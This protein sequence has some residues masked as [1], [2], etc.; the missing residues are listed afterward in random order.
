MSMS[1]Y[2]MDLRGLYR[3]DCTLGG[4]LYEK[5]SNVCI[6]QAIAKKFVSGLCHP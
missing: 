6:A 3:T 5:I 1:F 4:I 2:A